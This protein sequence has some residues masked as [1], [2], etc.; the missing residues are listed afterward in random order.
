ML[1]FGGSVLPEITLVPSEKAIVETVSDEE[2]VKMILSIRSEMETQEEVLVS[3]MKERYD[4][5]IVLSGDHAATS[6]SLRT[7][8]E[9]MDRERSTIQSALIENRFRLKKQLS[10]EEW[11]A[12]FKKK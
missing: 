5:L 2:R 4:E 6:D 10:R 11:K 1:L 12:I 8:F 7:V 9:H 3:L